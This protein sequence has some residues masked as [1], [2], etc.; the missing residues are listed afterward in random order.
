MTF[1]YR[2]HRR[3]PPLQRLETRRLLSADPPAMLPGVTDGL[4]PGIESDGLPGGDA[5]QP[6]LEQTDDESTAAI[7]YEIFRPGG[8][9]ITSLASVRIDSTGVASADVH[10]E[11]RTLPSELDYFVDASVEIP[12]DGLTAITPFGDLRSALQAASSAGV[13]GVTVHLA[14]G[15]YH[16]GDVG[17]VGTSL[18]ILGS[19]IGESIV[20]P[21]QGDRYA[22]EVRRDDLFVRGVTFAGGQT[23]LDIRGSS[24]VTIIDSE[25]T[26]ATSR[27]GLDIADVTSVVVV[28]S[29][30]YGNAAD[31]MSYTNPNGRPM[32]ILEVEVDA[33][34]NGLNGQWN[35]QGSTIHG[36]ASIIRVGGVYS[37]NPT[38]ISDVSRGESWNIGIRTAGA[39]VAEQRHEYLNFNVSGAGTAYLIGGDHSGQIAAPT[40]INAN[41]GATIYY[42]SSPPPGVATLATI[43]PMLRGNVVPQSIRF[44]ALG[45][46]GGPVLPPQPLPTVVV[47]LSDLGRGLAVDDLAVGGGFLMYS[48]QSVTTRFTEIDWM[49]GVSSHFLAVRLDGD[50][51]QFNDNV[52]WINFESRP[53]DRLIA[54]VDFGTDTVEPLAGQSGLVGGIDLG[55]VSSDLEVLAIAD[56]ATGLGY[57]MHSAESIFER[58]TGHPLNASSSHHFMMVRFEAGTW[59][60][61]DNQDWVVFTPSA[62]DRLIAAVDFDAD[63]VNLLIGQSGS[64]AGMNLGYVSGDIAVLANQWNGRANFGEFEISGTYLEI[65]S[66]A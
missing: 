41:P 42:P 61:N 44:T 1:S 2:S 13:S 50:Q 49:N 56:R 18:T 12:G 38:N 63:S 66:S 23:A 20:S 28:R 8:G 52:G 36:S 17:Y 10:W 59:Q 60:F 43:S 45:S 31:G 33:S 26:G 48:D 53:H 22:A 27:D 4:I 54:A 65:S 9:A 11:P 64:V 30:A 19:G 51:W 21:G 57:L 32:E 3:R 40:V 58:F 35:S 14:P 39:T 47:E 7:N 34:S 6:E 25:V 15:Q 37:N 62:S 46:T 5:S 55:Y 24:S 29:R 16:W